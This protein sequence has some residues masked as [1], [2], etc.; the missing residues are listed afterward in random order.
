MRVPVLVAIG[1]SF[2]ASGLHAQAARRFT[3]FDLG[4][5]FG[6]LAEYYDYPCP[7]CS[8]EPRTV[9]PALIA[10]VDR[11]LSAH[12]AIGAEGRITFSSGR[13]LEALFVTGS[14]S[15]SSRSPLWFRLGGG[16]LSQPEGCDV[17]V[18]ASSPTP[19]QC[20]SKAVFGGSVGAGARWPITER[21]FV[22]PE[23][24]YVQ[25][26][27]SRGRFALLSAGITVRLY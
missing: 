11:A 18:S 13:H 20:G 22:G 6:R 19:S 1:A 15:P 23:I 24:S 4:A 5:G 8:K 12:F 27:P 21:V 3:G 14:A 17:T 10:R 26:L 9:G 7:S 25:Q 2:A 16:I